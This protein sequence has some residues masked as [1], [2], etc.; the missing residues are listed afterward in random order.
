M[1]PITTT[2]YAAFI[3]VV[4]FAFLSRANNAYRSL[5][6]YAAI[7]IACVFIGISMGVDLAKRGYFVISLEVMQKQMKEI[8]LIPSQ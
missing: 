5:F 2:T 7:V 3:I 8:W 1:L 6:R 4:V